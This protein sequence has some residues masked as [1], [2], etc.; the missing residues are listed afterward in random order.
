MYAVIEKYTFSIP[1][2]SI[3]HKTLKTLPPLNWGKMKLRKKKLPIQLSSDFVSFFLD[4]KGN[5]E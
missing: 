2:L 5:P 4:N 1:E 3:D